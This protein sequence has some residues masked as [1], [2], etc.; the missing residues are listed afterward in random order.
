M[1]FFIVLLSLVCIFT[2]HAMVA[3]AIDGEIIQYEVYDDSG[4]LLT[5]TSDAEVGD[6]IL[7][8]DFDEYQIYE[9]DGEKCYARYFRTLDTPKFRIS[10]SKQSSAQD[11][12]VCLYMTQKHLTE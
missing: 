5:F 8:K 11:K 6:T 7:A 1:C 3:Y 4:N 10:R 9:I 2:P 12:K